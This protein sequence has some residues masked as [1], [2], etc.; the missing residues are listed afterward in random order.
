MFYIVAVYA[1]SGIQTSKRRIAISSLTRKN[2]MYDFREL[3][4]V[5]EL[6]VADTAGMV[7]DQRDSFCFGYDYCRHCSMSVGQNPGPDLLSLRPGNP[8]ISARPLSQR[9]CIEKSL[10]F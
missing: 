2:A 5:L 6:Q 9:L 1:A 8:H 4:K 10:H 7:L 3:L